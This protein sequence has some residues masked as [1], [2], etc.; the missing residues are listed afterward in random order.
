MVTPGIS[1]NDG[2]IHV[3]VNGKRV[4]SGSDFPDVFTTT[5]AVFAL[6]VN[7]WDQPYQGLIEELLIFD[8]QVLSEEEIKTYYQEGVIPGL[9]NENKQT[10]KKK[11]KTNTVWIYLG[12]VIVVLIIGAFVY[13]RRKK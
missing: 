11:V 9:D 12:I 7:Y 2:D 6:G 1:V 8:E 3:Y 5:E 4:F 10:D 13:A